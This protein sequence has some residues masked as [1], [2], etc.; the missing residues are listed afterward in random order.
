MQ[1]TNTGHGD[2]QEYEAIYHNPIASEHTAEIFPKAV[3]RDDSLL[4]KTFDF[5]L[6][7]ARNQDIV[8]LFIAFAKNYN[9]R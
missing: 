8:Y 2:R 9:A 7:K 5:I 1:A 6:N 4:E 3:A